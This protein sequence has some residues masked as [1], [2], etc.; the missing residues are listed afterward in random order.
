MKRSHIIDF[1]YKLKIKKTIIITTILIFK[2][3]NLNKPYFSLVL[4]LL[5]NIYLLKILLN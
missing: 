3:Q 2:Q 4:L 1:N 5:N